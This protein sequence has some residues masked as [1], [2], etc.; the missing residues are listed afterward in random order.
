LVEKIGFLEDYSVK[1]SEKS[2]P[3]DCSLEKEKSLFL[4]VDESDFSKVKFD[5]VH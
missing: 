1:M 3:L 4:L 2:E 5:K